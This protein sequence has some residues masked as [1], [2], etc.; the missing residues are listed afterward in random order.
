MWIYPFD[1]YEFLAYKGVDISFLNFEKYGEFMFE[2]V[3]YLLEE[4]YVF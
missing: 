4:Y 3:K 1:F 2:K